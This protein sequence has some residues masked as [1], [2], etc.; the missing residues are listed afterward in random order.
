MS[1]SKPALSIGNVG[2]LAIDAMIVTLDA[3]RV[4]YLESENVVA[5]VGND[6]FSDVGRG[7]L[8]TSLEIY[9][10]PATATE[11]AITFLQQRAPVLRG[12]NGAFAQQVFDFAQKHAFADVL[13]LLSA[14]ATRRLDSQIVGSQLRYIRAGEV[15]HEGLNKPQS[16]SK[17]EAAPS[18][19]NAPASAVIA[20][21]IKDI[22]KLEPE[23]E[24]VVLKRGTVSWHLDILFGESSKASS[25]S[26]TSSTSSSTSTP[27]LTTLIHFVHEGYNFPEGLGMASALAQGFNLKITTTTIPTPDGDV[28]RYNWVLPSSW[29]HVIRSPVPDPRIFG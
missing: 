2:Q 29:R 3:E 26:P 6:V 16:D 17:T 4:G 24:E 20:S 14:D 11:P 13:L 10:R 23:T 15:S 18:A 22:K 27:A 12:L 8:H 28:E 19:S 25:A 1:I 21:L 5:V 7:M 9:F